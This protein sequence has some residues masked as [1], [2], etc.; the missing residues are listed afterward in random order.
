MNL[1][2]QD[3][4][5]VKH[6]ESI[7]FEKQIKLK[8]TGVSTDSR[9]TKP[10]NIF[11]ALRGE[12][13]NGHNFLTKAIEAGAGTVIVEA[14]WAK[15]N[16]TMLS[17]LSVPRLVVANTVLALGQLANAYRR[18]FKIPVLAIG[19][20]NGKTTTKD[21]IAAVLSAKYN[22]L[23]T[24]GNLNNHIGVPLMLC[25]LEKK[26]T[27]AVIEMGTN[28]FG[29]IRYLSEILEP[30][31]AL[32]SNIGS[33][34]L[35][36]FGDLEGVAKAETEVFDWMRQQKPRSTVAFINRDD[37]LIQNHSKGIKKRITYGVTAKSADVKGA[38]VELDQNA[39]PNVRVKP[40]GKGSFEIRLSVPGYH[41]AF[42]ALAAAAV[43][44]HFRVPA[45]K[46]QRALSTFAAA[47]KRMQLARIDGITIL[48]DTY[49][50]NPDSAIA[51]LQ[52]LGAMKVS[53]KKIAVLADM[54]EL[55]NS[56]EEAHRRVGDAAARFGIEY[57]LTHGPLS[58]VTHDAAG[59]K[60]KAHYDQKNVLA[61]YLAEL[62]HTGDAVLVKGSRG[63]RM[64]T[65][66][67]FLCERLKQAA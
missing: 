11:I 51:A 55:G 30:T 20:S 54:L 41:N 23:S 19:G 43:G 27:M 9:T 2:Q 46:I 67:I 47:S 15:L 12:N 39:C 26:Q 5:S 35:E 57:L 36:F 60:F 1:T 34:H 38:V 37:G 6:I 64:E 53:G 7:G 28:H 40:K 62:V 25:R 18:K 21:M 4:L 49:N 48:N 33:E 8:F 45:S 16:P 56:A 50:S 13:F 59:V 17:S 29:E 52:T 63:M 22:V 31:H 42:N 65:V 58:K 44:L 66:V 32:I 61:E 24:E 14:D 10:G 3:V